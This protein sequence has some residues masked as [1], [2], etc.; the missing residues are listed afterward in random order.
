MTLN[1]GGGLV[2]LP[3]RATVLQALAVLEGVFYYRCCKDF[4]APDAQIKKQ[5]N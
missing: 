5:Q 1:R 3:R 4:T 2:R